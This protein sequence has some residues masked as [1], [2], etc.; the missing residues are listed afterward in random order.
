MRIDPTSPP[1]RLLQ[2]F[3]F[4]GEGNAINQ[5]ERSGNPPGVGG[6]TGPHLLSWLGITGMS[7]EKGERSLHLPLLRG[8][9]E[10]SCGRKTMSVD[11]LAQRPH[12]AATAR[13]PELRPF[14]PTDR[15]SSTGGF[16]TG[17]SSRPPPGQAT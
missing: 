2:V 9:K 4:P 12:N 5:M 7:R 17:S 15:L 6:F 10:E 14:P 1:P 16:N 8:F 3:H 11:V 13:G